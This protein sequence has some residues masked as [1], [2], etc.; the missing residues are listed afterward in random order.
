MSTKPG[1]VQQ[2]VLNH[3]R[4]NPSVQLM[5][6]QVAGELNLTKSQAKHALAKLVKSGEVYR[7]TERP[8]RFYPAPQAVD[9]TEFLSET[10]C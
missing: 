1:E 3:L 4:N 5:Y 9:L 2:I 8:A 7:T 6:G 10:G